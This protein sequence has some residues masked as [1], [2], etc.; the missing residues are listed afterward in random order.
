MKAIILGAPGS[1]KGTQAAR[2]TE[3]YGVP[4]VST[5]DI[6]RMNISK[7]TELGRKAKAHMDKGE[8]V[9]DELVI[10]IALDRIGA[11]D[12]KG[13]FLLDGF[14][15]TTPQAEALDRHLAGAG[16]KLDKALL[17]EVPPS[18]LV[19]RLTGRRVCG[20]CGASFHVSNI[21]PARDG[22]C[23]ACGGALFQR[24][25]DDEETAKNR[26][27]V[28][29]AQTAPLTAYYAAAGL[30]ARIDGT[31]SPEAVFEDIVEALSI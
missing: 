25:D 26:I 19:K 20:A 29:N 1:G 11:E 27:A 31:G 15:R 30:L 13:G 8:L 28:Y 17:L 16:A 4:A 21:P 6:F 9:P 23:D 3:R 14:P 7:G 12:C 5:G 24:S 22:V 10:A 2:I 18:E